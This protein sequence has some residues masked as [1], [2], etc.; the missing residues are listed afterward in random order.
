VGWGWGGG[1]GWVGGVDCRGGDDVIERG[2]LLAVMGGVAAKA[3]CL[4]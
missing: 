4:A 2:Q 3:V 1:G